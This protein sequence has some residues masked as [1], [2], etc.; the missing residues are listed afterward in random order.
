MTDLLHEGNTRR[1]WI[2]T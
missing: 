2:N 1:A